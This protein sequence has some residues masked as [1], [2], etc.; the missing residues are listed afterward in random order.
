MKM[1]HS[2]QW[3]IQWQKVKKPEKCRKCMKDRHF[4]T[5]KPNIHQNDGHNFMREGIRNISDHNTA[6]THERENRK[7]TY[8]CAQ[9]R[10]SRCH[11]YRREAGTCLR[12][13]F[14][15]EPLHRNGLREHVI[16]AMRHPRAPQQTPMMQLLRVV[17][18]SCPQNNYIVNLNYYLNIYYY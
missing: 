7:L 1:E 13:T 14:L 9:L 2:Y 4:N 17:R 11:G 6:S 18:A 5:S 12:N 3:Q 8:R 10:L 16:S 15:R